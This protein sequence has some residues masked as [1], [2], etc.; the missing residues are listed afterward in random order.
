MAKRHVLE[1]ERHIARQRELIA[2][3][4]A[5]GVDVS[6][7][8]ATLAALEDAQRLHIEH[9]RRLKQELGNASQA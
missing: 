7:H 1:G 8:H 2:E 9:V 5:L 6:R 4:L 3:M